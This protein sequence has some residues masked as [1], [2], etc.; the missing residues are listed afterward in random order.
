MAEEE[1]EAGDGAQRTSQGGEP[2][3]HI[4]RQQW[5]EPCQQSPGRKYSLSPTETPP[6][7]DNVLGYCKGTVSGSCAAGWKG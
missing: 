1:L 4:S 7:A 6:I 3:E 5:R 2:S